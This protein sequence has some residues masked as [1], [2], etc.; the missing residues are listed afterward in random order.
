MADIAWPDVTTAFPNEAALAAVPVP[1]QAPILER[2]NKLSANFFGGADSARFKLARL[3]L[4]AHMALTTVPGNAAA[5]PVTAEAIDDLSRQYAVM[6][7]GSHGA[8]GYG[9]AF[10]ELLRSS[11]GRLGLCS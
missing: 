3:Y 11:A 9:Q 10:D 4:A 2:V 6:V 1:L 7:T 5:G 8:T